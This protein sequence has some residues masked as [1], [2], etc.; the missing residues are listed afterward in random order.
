MN[1]QRNLWFGIGLLVA[2][3][4]LAAFA[5]A[6]PPPAAPRW[7][8]AVGDDDVAYLLCRRSAKMHALCDG[9]DAGV[10]PH[11]ERCFVG[12]QRL[13]CIDLLPAEAARCEAVQRGADECLGLGDAPWQGTSADACQQQAH[14][15]HTPRSL[16]SFNPQHPKET[17]R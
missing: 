13:P 17:H 11:C 9:I 16:S 6:V 10:R 8:E 15:R 12:N 5:S 14:A 7:C 2:A 4:T 1:V 3:V